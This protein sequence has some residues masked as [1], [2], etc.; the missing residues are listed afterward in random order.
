MIFSTVYVFLNL[1]FE[2]QP[3]YKHPLL[4]WSLW[5]TT[6]SIQLVLF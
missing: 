2:S 5:K 3:I 6:C 1:F 4:L